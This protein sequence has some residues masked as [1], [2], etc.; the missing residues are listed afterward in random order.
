MKWTS[1]SQAK[2][3]LCSE[4]QTHH[5]CSVAWSLPGL[6]GSLFRCTG[7]SIVT[8][9]GKTLGYHR[10]FHCWL[11]VPLNQGKKK[12]SRCC[13]C[14]CWLVWKIQTKVKWV[15]FYSHKKNM[16]KTK[17]L[18]AHIFTS[19][20]WTP[21]SVQWPHAV[22]QS[23]SSSHQSHTH[24]WALMCV[25]EQDW[26]LSRQETGTAGRVT[27]ACCSLW[28]LGPRCDKKSQLFFDD[29]KKLKC[30]RFFFLKKKTTKHW[31]CVNW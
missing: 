12:K 31:C 3:P 17:P 21:P 6:L 22:C 19:C 8:P 7:F 11:S 9:I 10:C 16:K 28:Q 15:C 27:A 13:S 29:S 14:S 24:L 4:G 2:A 5:C 18:S 1:I 20:T 30:F 25:A 26:V 23:E